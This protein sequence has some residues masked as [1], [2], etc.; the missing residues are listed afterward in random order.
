MMAPYA[1]TWNILAAISCLFL[2]MAVVLHNPGKRAHLAFGLLSLNLML[3]SLCVTAI[4]HAREEGTALFWIR[5]TFAVSSSLPATFY[6]FI[7][8]FPRQRFEGQRWLMAFL[9]GSVLVLALASYSPWYIEEI[10]VKPGFAPNVTYGPV[11]YFLSVTV[12]MAMAASFANLTAKLK[13]SVGVNRRQI[14]HVMLGVFVS[15]LLATVTNILAP[16]LG[17]GSFEAYGP[18]FMAVMMAIFAYA[19]IRYHLLDIWVIFS[20]T[21]LYLLVITFVAVTFALMMTVFP[22]GRGAGAEPWGLLPTTIAAIIIALVLVPLKERLQ[23]FLDRAFVKR[24]YDAQTLLTRV[25]RSAV[26]IVQLD[27]LLRTV[28]D[29]IQQTIG[30]K[31]VSVLLVDEE[32]PGSLVTEYSTRPLDLGVRAVDHAPLLDYV[33]SHPRPLVLEEILHARPSKEG[34]RLAGHLADLDAYLCLPLVS[35]SGLVGLLALGQKVS[36]D[37]YSAT[38]LD[39]FTALAAP[40]ATAIENARLYRKLEEANLHRAL[41]LSNMRGGVIAVDMAGKVTTVNQRA[42]EIL[43][44][45]KLGDPLSSLTKDIARVMKYTLDEGKGLTDF[46]STIEH[47]GGS[48]VAVVVSSSVLQTPDQRPRGAMALIYDLTQVKRLEQHVQRVDRLSSIGTL[49]AGMAHEI[50]NPLVSIKTLSQLLLNRYE[51]TDF[52]ETFAELV[53]HEVDRI[54]RIVARLLDFARPKPTQFQLQDLRQIVE[55]VIALVEN[56]ARKN[57]ITI[58]TLFPSEPG[59]VYGDEQ[60][61]HQVFLNLILNAI[62]AMKDTEGDV[63]RIMIEHG[64]MPGDRSPM[65]TLNETE[66]VKVSVTDS[67]SGIDQ[68]NLERLFTPFFTTKENGCGLG[69][70]VVHGIV[71]EHHGQIDVSSI[72]GKRTTFVVSLPVAASMSTVE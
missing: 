41:I 71:T 64:P 7:G 16:I 34:I 18:G 72:T 30:I 63:L 46:E 25:N 61:L 68:A 55:D 66:A 12:A 36:N 35:K 43:G 45:V 31:R 32:T 6:L 65:G 22:L 48:E 70:S 23:S 26:Q 39:V 27:E 10:S 14:H 60:Q 58:E 47:P 42:N 54:D 62:E 5:T 51:D 59:L 40:L 20:R 38:D 52:R 19:M 15:T 49:A 9:A 13:I 1:T 67:G 4:I 69:L 37:I 11:F 2:G 8:F 24:R 53:P 33:R 50:K 57:S 21:T 17:I 44:P 29:D 3:W 28:A 56:Q